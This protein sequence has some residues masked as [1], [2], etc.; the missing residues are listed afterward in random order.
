MRKTGPSSQ[1]RT[2]GGPSASNTRL[3]LAEARQGEA[4]SSRT[5]RFSRSFAAPSLL[6][7][8]LLPQYPF[9][10][11]AKAA[12]ASDSAMSRPG[13]ESFRYASSPGTPG[14][15]QRRSSQPGGP[16]PPPPLSVPP[17]LIDNAG[18]TFQTVADFIL[19]LPHPRHW[20]GLLATYFL[21]DP[22]R[23]LAANVIALITS[24]RTHR[25]VLRLSILTGL[26]WTAVILAVFAYIGFYRAWV[27]EVGRMEELFLQY[28]NQGQ[29][30][31]AEVDLSRWRGLGK[32][33]AVGEDWFAEEQEYE[34]A[35][36]L[37]VPISTSNLDLGESDAQEPETISADLRLHVVRELHG[38]HGPCDRR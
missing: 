1:R 25:V 36:E 38:I 2:V 12:I 34:A 20:P 21:L 27:P 23:A 14:A 11:T 26:F 16:P 24:P 28:G 10:T 9:D 35:V 4:T 17:Q 32:A 15:G 13:I 3:G 31:Y 5:P 37:L 8:S 7:S 6:V 19:G 30:P 22:I 18:E 29:V 33:M